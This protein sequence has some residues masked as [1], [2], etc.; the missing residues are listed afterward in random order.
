MNKQSVY[1]FGFGANASSEM[2]RA[3]VG[4]VPEGEEA[5]LYDYKLYTQAYSQIP[6]VAQE[7]LGEYW[8]PNFTSYVI[9]AEQGGKVKGTLW[10]LTPYERQLVKNWE[11]VGPWQDLK[12]VQVTSVKGP[13]YEAETEVIP[14]SQEVQQNVEGENYS[15]FVVP[16]KKSG[17]GNL[18]LNCF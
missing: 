11:L 5:V 2:M 6:K 9:K 17:F 10:K 7:I 15:Y 14:D 3:I 13:T 12:V 8:G 1:Y 18:Y 16:K 4:R